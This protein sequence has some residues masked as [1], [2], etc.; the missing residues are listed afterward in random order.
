M[1]DLHRAWWVI[2]QKSNFYERSNT[3]QEYFGTITGVGTNSTSQPHMKF[4]EERHD[5]QPGTYRGREKPGLSSASCLESGWQP[6]KGSCVH[7]LVTTVLFG[8]GLCGS[9]NRP[10]VC[11]VFHGTLLGL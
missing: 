2:N 9:P 10:I 8:S 5:F 6:G 7:M 1:G 11:S 4:A 3:E